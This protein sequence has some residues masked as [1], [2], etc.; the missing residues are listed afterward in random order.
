MI[1]RISRHQAFMETA[2]VWAKRSTCYRLNVG[3]VVVVD[4]R[5][6]SH[7][8]N[9]QRPGDAHCPGNECPGRNPGQCNTIHAEANALTRVPEALAPCEKHLYVTNSPC[10][11]C[12]A[13]CVR[14][15]VTQL[16]YSI[17]YRNT[18]GLLHLVSENIEVFQITPAGYLIN[19][20]TGQVIDA[21]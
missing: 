20:H 5:I 12:A 17:P 16:Y 1:G 4:G 9:G 11:E 2:F 8:Y 13:L 7:G 10:S 21:V 15:G 18:T 14:H 3:A 19:W 6:V